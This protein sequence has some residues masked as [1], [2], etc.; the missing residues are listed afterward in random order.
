MPGL[1]ASGITLRRKYGRSGSSSGRT[2]IRDHGGTLRL[3]D[4]EGRE[5]HHD[6]P[7]RPAQAALAGTAVA[8]AA[9]ARA[10]VA[11][12]AVAGDAGPRT[13]GA[14]TPGG[15]AA[16]RRDHPWPV[17]PGPQRGPH[18]PAGG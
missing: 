17:R 7:H 14:A 1:P 16:A 3:S 8:R 12:A 18:L 4:H 6:R 9:V 11:G 2:A 5:W 10:P 15:A 13:A